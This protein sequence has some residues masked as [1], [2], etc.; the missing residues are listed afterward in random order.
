MVTLDAEE[1][2]RACRV[3]VVDNGPVTV[4]RSFPLLEKISKVDVR[5]SS[6]R[7][8]AANAGVRLSDTVAVN[9]SKAPAR[10]VLRFT[11]NILRRGGYHRIELRHQGVSCLFQF[12]V[13]YFGSTLPRTMNC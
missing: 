2:G 6:L 1:E 10:R 4:C 9:A 3:R 8:S 13:V 7:S 12:L 5:G 11:L